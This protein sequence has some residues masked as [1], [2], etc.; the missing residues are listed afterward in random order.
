MPADQ[1]L[2][3]WLDLAPTQEVILV[4]KQSRFINNEIGTGIYLFMITFKSPIR[5]YIHFSCQFAKNLLKL[6]LM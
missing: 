1:A 6:L 3:T 2:Y 4:F 5:S